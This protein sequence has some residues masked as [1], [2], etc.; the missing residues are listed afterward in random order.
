MSYWKGKDGKWRKRGLPHVTKIKRK[1]KGIGTELK[2]IADATSGL[3]L[4]LEIQEGKEAMQRKEFSREYGAGT[5]VT[6]RLT[7]PWWDTGRAVGGDSAFSSVKT[8]KQCKL[9]GIDF[10]GVVKSA[11]T[12]FPLTFLREYQ[13]SKEKNFLA[14]TTT[15]ENV[16]LIALGWT[17][18]DRILSKQK[19]Q[20]FVS[21]FGSTLDGGLITKK[22][23]RLDD[24]E[25]KEVAVAVQVPR[26]IEEY[27]GASAKID[28]HNHYRQYGLALESAW[29]THTWWHRLF[30][31]V[32]GMTETDVHLAANFF[33]PQFANLTHGDC[34]KKLALELIQNDVGVTTPA[35][36][37]ST[38]SASSAPAQRDDGIIEA[39]DHELAP[40]HTIRSPQ[41]TRKKKA[42]QRKCVICFRVKHK[43]VKT[44]FFCKTCYTNEKVVLPLCATGR[45]CFAYHIQYGTPAKGS[46]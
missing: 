25:E 35:R 4:R 18:G 41:K 45:N 44:S 7:R 23:H 40:L 26:L 37:R 33:L 6:L 28:V 1:P 21:T 36:T 19:V 3:M 14:L 32:F 29:G 2:N 34:T 15:A 10:F 12:E 22:R 9:R 20:A 46:Q 42:I 11:H 39:H 24:G 30:A 27:F 43:K 8:A 31:T 5:A 17:Y 16:P 13:Y 38:T